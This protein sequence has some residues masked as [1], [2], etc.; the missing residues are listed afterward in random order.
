ML[1]AVHP[2]ELVTFRVTVKVPFR[3][4]V[5]EGVARVDVVPSPKSHR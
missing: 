2:S 1:A 3:L 5:C 4:K